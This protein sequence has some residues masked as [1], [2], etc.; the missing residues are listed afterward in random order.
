[1]RVLQHEPAGSPRQRLGLTDNGSVLVIGVITRK[2]DRACRE[3]TDARQCRAKVSG[4][5][6]WNP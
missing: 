2:L 6:R 4:S 3:S 5:P 1:M